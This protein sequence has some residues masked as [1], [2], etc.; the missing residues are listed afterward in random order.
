MSTVETTSYV[1]RYLM[2]CGSSDKLTRGQGVACRGHGCL[3]ILLDRVELLQLG[4]VLCF[5]SGHHLSDQAGDRVVLGHCEAIFD[6]EGDEEGQH[7]VRHHLFRETKLGIWEGQLVYS[8]YCHYH[9]WFLWGDLG[10]S[11]QNIIDDL[12]L[13]HVLQQLADADQAVHPET[14]WFDPSSTEPTHLTERRVVEVQRL[15]ILGNNAAFRF[16]R[17]KSPT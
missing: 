13:V 14:V 16:C 10:Q 6:G 4:A 12:P 9:S 3:A 17:S 7:L 15:L 2:C 11:W 8:N 1:W 5:Y